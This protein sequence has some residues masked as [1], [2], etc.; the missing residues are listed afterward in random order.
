MLLNVVSAAC[1][2]SLRLSGCVDVPILTDLR[3]E[4]ACVT[5]VQFTESRDD[6]EKDVIKMR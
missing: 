1:S 6:V 5:Y 2:G 3:S 4:G